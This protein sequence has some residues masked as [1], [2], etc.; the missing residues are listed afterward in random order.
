MSLRPDPLGAIPP[1]TVRVAQ[2]AFPRGNRLLRVRDELGR[3]Y[4]D[5]TFAA[6]YPTRGQPAAAPWRLATILVLQFLENLPDRDAA[7]AVRARIDWKYVLGLELTDPG[8]DA[9]VLS[10]FRT[11][12]VAGGAEEHLLEAL[13]VRVQASGLLKPHGRQ[14]TDSTH[15]VAAV[16]SLN[17]LELVLETVRHA[18]NAVAAMAPTWLQTWLPA[19]WLVRYGPRVDNDRLP[20]WEAARRALAVRVGTDGIALLTATEAAPDLAALPALQTLRRVWW[21]QFQQTADGSLVWRDPDDLPP[22][23]QTIRSPH[24][25]DARL[26]VKRD[27]AWIGGKLHVTETCDTDA[28]HLLT[29]VAT[30][31]APVPDTAMT[32]PIEAD[33]VARGR[34]P[35]EHDVDSGYLDAANL[36]A[37]H[38]RGIDLVGPPLAD[39][40]WQAQAGQGFAAA[41]FTVDWDGRRAT[42]PGERT[43]VEWRETTSRHGTPV[44]ALRFAQTDC[45]AC[46]LRPHCTRGA[47][48]TLTLRPR[49]EHEALQAAR[50]RVDAGDVTAGLAARAGVEGTMSQVVAVGGVR[51]ARYRGLPKTHL[52]HLLTAVAIN[53]LR[54]VAWWEER[55]RAAVRPPRF[56]RVATATVT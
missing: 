3:L 32:T 55:P 31:P 16:R 56:V 13:L 40:S 36:V 21:Q 27:R 5:A 42:C 38:V 28:P 51:R 6:L 7:E 37:S 12:L 2:A 30:T 48:R 49:A 44:V 46:R 54:L 25:P 29:H 35:T 53:L 47:A 11:R 52:A 14:R 24:D 9:S 20:S 4:D 23:S 10:E 18:L 33:L 39:T 50:A 8:F 22:A 34:A 15:V 17:R 43:S 41:D 19:D 26:G 1:E 45:Q